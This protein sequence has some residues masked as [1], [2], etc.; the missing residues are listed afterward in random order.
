MFTFKLIGARGGGKLGRCGDGG[1]S[2]S[3][4]ND[5]DLCKTYTKNAINLF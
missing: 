2:D 3:L 4:G 5:V 1:L